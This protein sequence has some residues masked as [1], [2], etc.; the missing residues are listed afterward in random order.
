MESWIEKYRPTKLN[1]FIGDKD[2]I[3]KI[4]CFLKQFTD[5]SE[6]ENIAPT[7]IISGPNGIGKTLLVDL[8][9]KEIGINKHNGNIDNI[10]ITRKSKNKKTENNN[11]KTVNCNNFIFVQ[12]F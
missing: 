5:N 6:K 9:L 2:Q 8:A 1:E 7:I 10:V 12:H 4:I 11:N 3:K